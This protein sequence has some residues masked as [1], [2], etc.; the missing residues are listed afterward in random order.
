VLFG[1]WYKNW[2]NNS[3]MST[4]IPNYIS[5]VNN[6]IASLSS[7]YKVNEADLSGFKMY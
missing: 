3:G 4:N 2:Y 5:D 1:A 7:G 6:T